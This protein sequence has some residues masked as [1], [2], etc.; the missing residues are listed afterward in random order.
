MVKYHKFAM[1][2]HQQYF[3]ESDFYLWYR[4]W[5][6]RSILK[7]K[8]TSKELE[9]RTELFLVLNDTKIRNI[10]IHSFD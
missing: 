5:K 7:A 10:T 3:S 9:A 4:R 8:K 2:G 1:S 6:G